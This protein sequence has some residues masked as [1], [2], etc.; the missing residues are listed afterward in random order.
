M[1]AENKVAACIITGD[2]YNEEEVKRLLKSLEPHVD[3]I[4]INYN[5]KKGKLN[6]QKWTS[7]PVV[8]KKFKWEEDFGLARNQS[9]SLVPRDEFDYYLWIDTDDVLVGEPGAMDE[10]IAS[11]D[12]YTEGVFLRYEYAVDP[13]TG[14]VVVEQWR[15]RL[16]A[17]NTDWEWVFP[18]HEVCRSV[19]GIQY[20]KRDQLFIRHQRTSGDDRG[21]RE[22]NRRIIAN[23]AAKY[24]EESR[25]QFYLAGETLAEADGETDPKRKSEL[26]EMALVAYNK[27]REMAREITD[28]IYL[29]TARI[30]ELHRM[31]GDHASAIEADLECIA[32][33]PSWPDGYVGAA[34]SCMELGDWP[35]MKAFADMA[36]K[37]G[38]P[39]TAASIEPMMAGFT[40][41]FLR[42]IANEELGD[43]DQALKDFR[44]A[45]KLWNPPNGQLEEKIK[46]LKAYK[47]SKNTDDR[48]TKRKE[49][50]GT[51]QDK[52]ICF[53]TQPIP[54]VWHPETLKSGGA[55]GAETCIMKLAP[56]FAADG[57]RVCVFGTP[58]EYRGVYED[59]EYWNADE[60]LPS[61]KFKVFISS[62]SPL[63]FD[64]TPISDINFLWMHDVNIGEV[65]AK[66]MNRPD[67]VIGLTNWH[68]N[69][70]QNLYNLSSDKMATIPNG[71]DMSRFP[72]EDWDKSNPYRFIY[73]SSADRGLDTLLSLWPII[74]GKFPEAELHT[75]YGWNIIDKIIRSSRGRSPQV[76]YLEEFKAKCLAQ[77]DICGGE[78]GGIYQHGRIN[79]EE[80]A[81]EMAKCSVWTYPTSFME[82]FCITAIEMQMSGVIPVTSALAALNETVAPHYIKVEGWPQ[83]S[84]YQGQWLNLL[85]AIIE[86]PEWAEWAR[87]EAKEYASQFSWE[88]AYSKWNDL[89]M[90]TG[91]FENNTINIPDNSA[92]VELYV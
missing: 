72:I 76:S 3:G 8:Y 65:E 13:E 52:S 19:S 47:G 36:T 14:T 2:Q 20:A 4:F 46:D 10:L 12:P 84:A 67:K 24:P 89:I 68:T 1:S 81:K 85:A 75:Y 7:L 23:A 77:I 30:A 86:Q 87:I 15:E 38:Q 26:I 45:K 71:I 29:A 92:N 90:D 48:W 50:R 43:I 53:F 40:P 18:I 51:R 78:E 28:D 25:Y 88:Y 58:G 54:D 34:K 9:F 74:K 55:G 66:V 57:W 82:T 27:Y 73:S 42:G 56:M 35:R 21:A 11:L 49:L 91:K 79:Q 64:V 39:S 32:I 16:L 70:L 37:C 41:L 5:G 59:V 63:P 6:W 62:R 44:A 60:Y 83:N 61:E 31:K 80:L 22:R 33:Y 69:H 17:T